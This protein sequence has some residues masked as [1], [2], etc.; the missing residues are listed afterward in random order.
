MNKPDIET[1]LRIIRMKREA[2][3]LYEEVD[4][5]IAKIK[6]NY[7]SARF[8][9]DL[10]E[11]PADMVDDMKADGRWL[12]FEIV[13]NLAEMN[14]GESVWTSATFKPLTFSSKSLKRCPESLK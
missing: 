12:K 5:E 10:E 6:E 8:D 11:L 2:Q 13:D 14:A 4:K 1:V 7:G 3:E 9:Y